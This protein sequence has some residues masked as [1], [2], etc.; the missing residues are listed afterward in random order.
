MVPPF[1]L[2]FVGGAG[3]LSPQ[4]VKKRRQASLVLRYRVDG[5]TKDSAYL[6][7]RSGALGI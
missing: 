5:M 2:F 1:A 4:D 6:C 3:W 7:H